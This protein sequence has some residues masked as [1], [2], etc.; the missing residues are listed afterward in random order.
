MKH[1]LIGREQVHGFVVL[2]EVIGIRVKHLHLSVLQM[3]YLT[4]RLSPS[5]MLLIIKFSVTFWTIHP[6]TS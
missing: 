2:K 5:V 6:S 4:F 3:T 1:K